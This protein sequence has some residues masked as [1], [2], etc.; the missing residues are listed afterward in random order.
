MEDELS[1][2]NE[3]TRRLNDE[4]LVEYVAAYLKDI[5]K[6]GPKIISLIGGPASG[7][8][9]LAQRLGTSLGKAIVLSTD[10]Y[11]KGDRAWRRANVEDLGK[12]PVLKYDPEY[13][14]Q[15]VKAVVSLEEGEEVGVPTYDGATGIAISQDPDHKPDPSSYPRKIKGRQD[16]ILVE[17]DFQFLSPELVDKIIYLDVDDNVRLEN[18]VYRD[19]VERKEHDDPAVSEQKTRANFNLRQSAQFIPHTLPQKERAGM[20]IKAHAK[21]LENPTPK[22]K[23]TYTYDVSLK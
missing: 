10:N 18:R 21:P 11:L 15:Q 3:Q 5:Q 6:E 2:M 14:N 12:D 7:K 8:S 13:L 23:F 4:Q 17:G 16:F 22:A 19:A 20:V 1:L 9:T